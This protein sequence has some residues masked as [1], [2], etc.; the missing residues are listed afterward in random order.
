MKAMR[1]MSFEEAI[2]FGEGQIGLLAQTQDAREGLA[3]FREKRKPQ[4]TGK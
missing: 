2:A 3:A 1:S 4:W